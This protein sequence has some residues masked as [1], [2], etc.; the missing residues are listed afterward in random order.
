VTGTTP[1]DA[2]VVPG[3]DEV[4]RQILQL[5]SQVG[6]EVHLHARDIDGPDGIGIGSDVPVVTASVF[7]IPVA[8]TL[9][10]LGHAGVLD[11]AEE[12]TITPGSGPASP[13][14]LATFRHPARLSLHDLGLLMMG[15]SDN[16]ATDLV[17]EK[18]GRPAINAS[19]AELGLAVT[20]VP[21][22][23]QELLDTIAEELGVDYDDDERTLAAFPMSRIRTLSALQPQHTC[24]TTAAEMTRLLTMIWRDEAAQPEACADVRRW[25]GLQVWPHRLR[26]GFHDEDVAISGKTG[27]L[28]TVR[29]EVG[30]VE[31]G[32]GHR[33]AVAVFTV[34]EDV[35]ARVPERDRFIGEAA[36]LAVEL[37]RRA[38]ATARCGAD[39]S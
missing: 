25:M 35:R 2:A 31:Y 24:R 23:C 21:Q 18:V 12:I 22:S 28:P 17:M 9:A 11:L 5:A 14:G 29:N 10:R 19:L 3:W 32:D 33:Y 26:S 20:A 13:Y 8:V 38:G 30:V 15:L 39:G 6:V 34:A 4:S 36:T 37:L 7:K 27:T 1:G 16:V